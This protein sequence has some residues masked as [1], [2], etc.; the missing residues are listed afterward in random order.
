M[1]PAE[2]ERPQSEIGVIE[3]AKDQGLL[4]FVGSQELV[5]GNASLGTD[6]A[7]S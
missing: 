7:E 1:G 3:G 5:P 6:C 2:G 4:I